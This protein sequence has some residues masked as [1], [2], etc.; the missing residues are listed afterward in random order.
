MFGFADRILTEEIQ[1]QHKDEGSE[2]ISSNR[3][4]VQ[5]IFD[6]QTR[7][8]QQYPFPTYEERI[9]ALIRL[10]KMVEANQSAIIEAINKDYGNRSSYETRAIEIMTV[11]S[12]SAYYRRHL[13]RFMRPQ[14]RKAFK[15][16]P[17]SS[18]KVIPQPKGIVGVIA[19]WNGPLV[20]AFSPA[21]TALAAGNRV[22]IRMAKNSRNI[23]DLL[24]TLVSENF[25]PE[26][27]H[28]V[29]ETSGTIFG[30]LAF[31]HLF[32]TGSSATGRHVMAQAAAN[33]T[34]V[35]LELGGKSPV[36]IAD[37]FDIRTA[38][39]RIMQ[40]K[41]LN[42]G[43]ICITPDQ[44]Y[45]PENKVGEFVAHAREM[46]PRWYPDVSSDDYTCIV[47]RSAFDRLMDIKQD[48]LEKGAKLIRVMPGSVDEEQ[49][50][51]PMYLVLNATNDMRLMNEEIFGPFLPIIPYEFLDDVLADLSSKE[52]PL[53]LYIFTNNRE[54]E[55]KVIYNSMSGGVSVNAIGKHVF[56]HS[57]PFGG[58]GNS[59]MGQYH[60][61]EGFLEFSKL[62][63]VYRESFVTFDRYLFPPYGAKHHKILDNLI[64]WKL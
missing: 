40:F 37:D 7:A 50:K 29:K 19:P 41:C 11:M 3:D 44:L 59:G 13:K 14:R 23:N 1:V 5:S 2:V 10:E 48:A 30:S 35:T 36:I 27:L 49:R 51:I 9:D 58:V 42:G 57:M 25:P 56:Q 55:N 33:L 8:H 15:L 52:A 61:F 46:V 47:D 54:T 32:F 16:A 4:E 62:R 43:Q 6:I 64:K 21:A 53:A 39:Q 18:N 63:P 26:Q 60:G 38:V 20:L 17:G 34:P 28:V 31:N 24:Y 12:D 45:V 22:M